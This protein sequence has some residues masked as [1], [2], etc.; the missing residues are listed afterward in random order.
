MTRVL[1]SV[2]LSEGWCPVGHGKLNRD[3][4][5]WCPDCEL[6]FTIRKAPGWE[7]GTCIDITLDSDIGCHTFGLITF[8]RHCL[9]ERELERIRSELLQFEA[10]YP[11]KDCSHG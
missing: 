1:P 11:A 6:R 8:D 5:G 2:L 7:R 9:L 4:V 3:G 10:S